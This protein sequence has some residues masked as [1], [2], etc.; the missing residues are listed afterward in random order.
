MCT[1]C[2]QASQDDSVFRYHKDEQ[3]RCIRA[4]RRVIRCI[5]C[6]SV[7]AHSGG[8]ERRRRCEACEA[9]W[10]RFVE[11]GLHRPEEYTDEVRVIGYRRRKHQGGK[12]GVL[13]AVCS[14][15]SNSAI[16]LSRDPRFEALNCG[17]GAE[18]DRT[19]KP[20]IFQLVSCCQ[21][22]S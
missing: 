5:D 17:L 12:G 18:A 6:G 2:T 10:K 19:W 3:S 11:G 21:S 1:A 22:S 13:V 15:G 20:Y 14:N 8:G 9:R 16:A 4:R 7:C